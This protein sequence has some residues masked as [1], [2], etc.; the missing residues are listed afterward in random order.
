MKCELV[1][2]HQET[3]DQVRLA[4]PDAT[5][6]DK[7]SELMKAFADPTRLKILQALRQQELCVC[8]L[9]VI[10]E[11]TQSSVSHQLSRL[12]KQ[13]LVKYRK[14]GK[15]VYYSLDDEHVSEILDRVLEHIDHA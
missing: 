1:I 9:A 7:V 10:I 3:V 15:I 2:I 14:D 13:H 11:A 12:R 5:K 8:D 6:I 4:I